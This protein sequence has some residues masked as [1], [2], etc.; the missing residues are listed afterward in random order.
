M[1]E[2]PEVF[3]FAQLFHKFIGEECKLEIVK[4][5]YATS[6]KV[7]A[8]NFRKRLE[9]FPAK[10]IDATNHGKILILTFN[11]FSLICKPMLEGL[12]A[13]TN[14]GDILF[15]FPSGTISFT[16]AISL[17]RLEIVAEQTIAEGPDITHPL[18]G[19][20]DRFAKMM[21]R[22]RVPVFRA[23]IDQKVASGC[24]NYMRAEVLG[25]WTA[26]CGGNSFAPASS[27]SAEQ[28]AVLW[29]MLCAEARDRI[30]DPQKKFL[31]YK[32][33]TP[34]KDGKRTFWT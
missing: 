20:A 5:Q 7:I 15:N 25:K 24:G 33:G 10:L 16:D 9:D 14:I 1:P 12:F 6:P 26:E 2:G 22:R 21:S 19:D 13:E 30:K 29:E 11:K 31:F 27:L 18:A 28:C 3:L 4:G 23:I 32:C 34:V 17:A 8:V